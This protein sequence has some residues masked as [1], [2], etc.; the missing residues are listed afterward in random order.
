MY[1]ES[2]RRWYNK[3]EPSSTFRTPRC[4]QWE[5]KGGVI[6][7]EEIPLCHHTLAE[8]SLAEKEGEYK[9]QSIHSDSSSLAAFMSKH[10][11]KQLIL[12][13]DLLP[14]VMPWMSLPSKKWGKNMPACN[15]SDWIFLTIFTSTGKTQSCWFAVIEAF[16]MMVYW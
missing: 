10:Y 12:P 9:D 15:H 16:G 11:V 1:L 5:R 2:D 3:E 8:E 7:R 4:R 14:N 6:Q 13:S